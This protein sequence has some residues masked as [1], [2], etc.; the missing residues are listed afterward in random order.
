MSTTKYQVLYR[1]INEATNTVITNSDDYEYNSVCEF[2]T[3]P[4]HKIFMP[5]FEAE[6]TKEQQEMISYGNSVDNIKTN[7]LFAY[8]GPKK[9]FHK[10][11]IPEQDAY[12]IRDWTLLKR[13]EIG[14][15]G[16]FSKKYTTINGKT[17]E[18]GGTVV[19]LASTIKKDYPEIFQTNGKT[20]SYNQEYNYT[21]KELNETITQQVN[22]TLKDDIYNGTYMLPSSTVSPYSTLV[23][24][25]TGYNVYDNGIY[26]YGNH[27]G[28][29]IY[30]GKLWIGNVKT[31]MY[32]RWDRYY[33]NNKWGYQY[34]QNANAFVSGTYNKDGVYNGIC[35]KQE[36]LKE[37]KIPGH[38][39]EQT[40]APY[41]IIDTYKKIKLSPWF[42]NCQC[43][44][45]NTAIE[46]AKLLTEIIGISNVKVVKLVP[47][48]QHIK[49]K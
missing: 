2:Y 46:K 21:T 22:L 8:D 19:C 33:Y 28:S 9:M 20:L 6:A 23:T 27:K 45:L 42:I 43:S 47:I 24:E 31:E 3:D 29:T 30:T 44:S 17:P 11:W 7:M 26:Y 15:Q 10:K 5:E 18:V 41:V 36:H 39:E 32:F 35:I 16:D 25:H 13:E 48:D 38:Y 12:E 1:Y 14:D 34:Y 40:D 4:N 49:L 37:T